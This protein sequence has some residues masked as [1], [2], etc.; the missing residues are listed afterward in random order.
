MSKKVIQFDDIND[1]SSDEEKTY[2][3]DEVV[4]QK[5]ISEPFSRGGGVN[6]QKYIHPEAE[7]EG[8][9]HASDKRTV[10]SQFQDDMR[11]EVN[12]LSSKQFGGAHSITPVVDDLENAVLHKEKKEKP[13]M[14]EKKTKGK[15]GEALSTEA[16]VEFMIQE[17]Q[18]M[19]AEFAALRAEN[20]RLQENLGRQQHRASKE[21]VIQKVPD[22]KLLEDS[23]KWKEEADR[24]RQENDR[25]KDLQRKNDIEIQKNK[26][27]A[28]DALNHP[29][30]L[31][32]SPDPTNKKV[33]E[34]DVPHKEKP[35]GILKKSNSQRS[36]T[37]A[38]LGY[39]A[40]GNN[41]SLDSQEF[42]SEKSA[43]PRPNKI[44]AP[45][46]QSLASSAPSSKANSPRKSKQN[47]KNPQMSI[48]FILWQGGVLWK[49][50]YNGKGLPEKRTIMLKRALKAG[51]KSKA[52]S[53]LQSED[54]EYDTG[55]VPPVAYIS[56][57]PTLT[58][59]NP[60]KFEDANNARE[61]TLYEGAHVVTGY[62][63]PA[64]WKSKSRGCP[65]PPEELCFS[66]VTSSRSLDLAAE[67]KNE[68]IS[69]RNAIHTILVLMSNNTDWALQNLVRAAPTWKHEQLKAPNGSRRS[70][71]NEHT[72]VDDEND[73]KF[74]VSLKE[75]MFEA[76]RRNDYDRLEEILK[77]GI[78][79]N[80]MEDVNKDTPLMIACRANLHH[81]VHLCLH[82]GAKNDPHPDFGQ[83]ALH[84]AVEGRS[85]KCA[86]VLLEAAAPSQAD[87]VISNLRDSKGRSPLHLSA[88]M[89]DTKMSGL[90]IAHGANLSCKDNMGLTPLHLCSSAGHKICLSLFLDHGGDNVID[91]QDLVGSTPLHYASENGHISCVR[92][93]LETAANP[94][95]RNN[96]GQTPYNLAIAQG[97]HQIGVLLMEYADS[98]A[99]HPHY[100]SG[101]Q[102]PQK[103][104]AVSDPSISFG[105]SYLPY[106]NG[107][108]IF[109]PQKQDHN[110]GTLTSPGMLPRPYSSMSSKNSLPSSP[111]SNPNNQ[112]QNLIIT[113]PNSART[114]S[115]SYNNHNHHNNTYAPLSARERDKPLF[116]GL[117]VYTYNIP[118]SSSQIQ[119]S[120]ST[121]YYQDSADNNAYVDPSALETFVLYDVVWN[122][123][124]TEE[125]YTYYLDQN[126]HSQWDD[127]R[128]HGICTY[129]VEGEGEGETEQTVFD[130]QG[131][132][133]AFTLPEKSF[134]RPKIR[135]PQKAFVKQ[136]SHTDVS[137]EEEDLENVV[138]KKR[139]IRLSNKTDDCDD[140]IPEITLNEYRQQKSTR[141]HQSEKQMSRQ[142]DS[143]NNR[144]ISRETIG[145]RRVTDY[146]S[147]RD[148]DDT[149]FI[150]LTIDVE[151]SDLP[152]TSR[153]THKAHTSSHLPTKFQAYQNIE[154]NIDDIPVGKQQSRHGQTRERTDD[155]RKENEKFDYF[156]DDNQE[157]DFS[158][159]GPEEVSTPAN[160]RLKTKEVK[161]STKSKLRESPTKTKKSTAAPAEVNAKKDKKS[162][163]P[164]K[165]KAVAEDEESDIYEEEDDELNKSGVWSDGNDDQEESDWDKEEVKEKDHTKKKTAAALNKKK[166]LSRETK[167]NYKPAVPALALNKNTKEDG[168]KKV[169]PA[170]KDLNLE[171]L[172][173]DKLFVGGKDGSYGN[174]G[175]KFQDDE[176]PASASIALKN[177]GKTPGKP[178]SRQLS[179]QDEEAIIQ[180]YVNKLKDGIS[181]RD[182]RREMEENGETRELIKRFL[183]IA[184]TVDTE[185]ALLSNPKPVTQKKTTEAKASKDD[186][187]ALTTDATLGKYAKMAL[188]GIPSGS[189]AQKMKIDGISD[190]VA[191]PLLVAMGMNVKSESSGEESPR[192]GSS[193]RSSVPLLKLHWNT[194]PADKVE[195]SVWASGGD[196]DSFENIEEFEKLFGTQHTSRKDNEI[197]MNKESEK[198]RLYLLDV[199]RAQNVTITLTQFKSFD[200][201]DQLLGAVCSLD[202]HHGTL[203]ADKLETLKSILPTPAEC[204][205]LYLAAESQHPAEQFLISAHQFY[206]ELPRRLQ[207]F[208]SV[209]TIGHATEVLV[210]KMRKLIDA[211]NEVLSS[212]KLARLLQKMLKIGNLMNEGTHKGQALGFTLDSLLSMVNTKGVDKRTSVLDYVVK[213]M[214]DKGEEHILQVTEDL[215]FDNEAC[216]TS[217]KDT[218]K[219]VEN[220]IKEYEFLRKEIQTSRESEV[221]SK[222]QA[223]TA[224]FVERA[225]VYLQESS[226]YVESVIKLQQIMTKKI[227]SIIEYFGE[228]DT[229]DTTKIFGVLQ[230]FKTA[231]LTSIETYHRRERMRNRQYSSGNVSM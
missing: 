176:V 152:S 223:Y 14:K 52:V 178:T 65:L 226:V 139:N 154:D 165:T 81:I 28:A 129:P 62:N 30:A 99:K 44:R 61:L 224:Q 87:A 35:P 9:K 186:I 58:W 13:K 74:G 130:D 49:I 222:A 217:G 125:G 85:H 128:I 22:S 78:S 120:L 180:N 56:F 33:V 183:E 95:S 143:N 57:P 140:D 12:V 112:Q 97:H 193:R 231:L 215:S 189:I 126:N 32:N 18:A 54:I 195:K 127:P 118:Y 80:L 2:S 82:Y 133:V 39:L 40:L 182:V 29:I 36:S 109:S 135:S 187:K 158:A 48:P 70:F 108:T 162:I 172:K 114:H 205:K 134:S 67:S 31:K 88:W 164:P 86:T 115:E 174:G 34:E 166:D 160:I 175:N 42:N 210:D 123:Y 149:D 202:N 1:I 72:L 136:P 45:S 179:P 229:T 27:L 147:T 230:Q 73:R 163:V 43:L 192:P 150:P 219:Q 188:M 138:I 19:E 8:I 23:T 199:K 20:E 21:I 38:D 26:K 146:N 191:Q 76:T 218:M 37:S 11:E 113:M 201:N 59:S 151:D 227:V 101:N 216:R 66:V 17:R 171:D 167:S 170:K 141:E 161:Q 155:S 6:K 7:S 53:V 10:R 177:G 185:G 5:S 91:M 184:D 122:V 156:A 214:L 107:S 93:L 207:C 25:L 137:S 119:T 169:P 211:C 173:R 55:I 15:R 64:F 89:G 228:E 106:P 75:E 145:N 194:V 116:D 51:P 117:Q 196:E 100:L 153:S 77:R 132:S 198:L 220:Y 168:S 110:G 204:K 181:L 84:A 121:D 47:S 4:L 103:Q 3:D 142:N 105:Q 200:Q 124:Q 190:D 209:V 41:P 203:T 69:W 60:A 144:L 197:S 83:T 102:L 92:L 90:L 94:L 212:D 79:V 148:A 111:I 131:T 71:G 98:I 16:A 63:S 213:T 46:E 157:P 24:L 206:P 221:T 159:E 208:I 225:E 96:N 50:P 68:A 104:R